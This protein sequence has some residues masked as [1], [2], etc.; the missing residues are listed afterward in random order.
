MSESRLTL[1]PAWEGADQ[2]EKGERVSDM[3]LAQVPWSSEPSAVK[4]DETR[5]VDTVPVPGRDVSE[6]LTA[7]ERRECNDI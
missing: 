7:K 2:P 3:W 5:R 6:W 1:L 4:N